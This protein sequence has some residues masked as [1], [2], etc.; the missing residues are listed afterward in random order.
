MQ[1]SRPGKT[2][3]VEEEEKKKKRE[4]DEGAKAPESCWGDE[5]SMELY[6]NWRHFHIQ[7]IT[8]TDGIS[9]KRRKTCF[10][11]FFFFTPASDDV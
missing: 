7:I 9:G 3:E 5:C 2:T 10:P 1:S 4:Q 8:R 11:F 6:Q